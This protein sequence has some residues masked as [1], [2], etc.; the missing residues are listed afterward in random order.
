MFLDW[1]LKKKTML[2]FCYCKKKLL[3][4]LGFSVC[5]TDILPH[6]LCQLFIAH[7]RHRAVSL[8]SA[9]GL[10]QNM[11]KK[12][13]VVA[14]MFSKPHL[15]LSFSLPDTVLPLPVCS[16]IPIQGYLPGLLYFEHIIYVTEFIRRQHV[17]AY[18]FLTLIGIT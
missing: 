9:L 15:T 3:S 7:H 16:F 2:C 11:K 6:F 14:N 4:E 18:P 13:F 8:F 12:P 5:R 17:Q 1:F 10:V